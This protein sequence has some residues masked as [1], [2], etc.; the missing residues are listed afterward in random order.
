M[1]A[2]EPGIIPA[3]PPATWEPGPIDMLFP[4]KLYPG[5][6]IDFPLSWIAVLLALGTSL[7]LI[8]FVLDLLDVMPDGLDTFL[9]HV[10]WALRYT[11]PQDELTGTYNV[12][13]DNYAPNTDT[14][15]PHDFK[16]TL[17]KHLRL[18]RGRWFY[19]NG[20]E[21]LK[22]EVPVDA[23]G[24]LG[25]EADSAEPITLPLPIVPPT[26]PPPSSYTQGFYT[27]SKY[28]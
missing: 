21:V 5:L 27:D 13:Y 11:K 4:S 26:A 24:G 7:Y 22:D 25:H 28:L 1:L 23:P 8:F 19:D 18:W 17:S 14:L 2:F 12:W 6:I 9:R 16:K 20:D 3:E 15:D 10:A